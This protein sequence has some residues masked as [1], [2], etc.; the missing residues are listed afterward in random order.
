MHP[1]F[2]SLTYTKDSILFLYFYFQNYQTLSRS[3]EGL[4]QTFHFF[5]MLDGCYT[6]KIISFSHQM[7]ASI[8]KLRLNLMI[9]AAHIDLLVWSFDYQSRGLEFKP[10]VYD[11]CENLS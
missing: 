11:V 8:K 4:K 7:K 2:I 6:M 10:C 9:N 1:H 3:H 5:M